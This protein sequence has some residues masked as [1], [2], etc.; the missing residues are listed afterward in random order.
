MSRYALPLEGYDHASVW[1]YDGQ[2]MTYFAH[3]WRNASD[4][5]SDPDITVNWFTRQSEID[6]PVTLAELISARTGA[7]AARVVRAMATAYAPESPAVA[8]LA[9]LLGADA[10]DLPG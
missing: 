7:S 4:S 3:L 1:G 2:E 10:S 6:S 9:E 8:E 5:W